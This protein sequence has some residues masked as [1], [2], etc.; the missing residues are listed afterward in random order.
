MVVE[1]GRRVALVGAS[2]SG[3]STA[4]RIAVG[5]LPPTEGEVVA[6]GVVLR[7]APPGFLAGRIGYVDQDIVLFA[8]SIRDNITLFDDS[9]ADADVRA[10]SG[11]G[12]G[13]SR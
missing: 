9:I 6:N 4:A 1:P 2:G 5:L 12:S 13:R 11:R 8:G 3:K 10:S 7:D